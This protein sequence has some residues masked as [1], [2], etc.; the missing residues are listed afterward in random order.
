MCLIHDVGDVTF[1]VLFCLPC[2]EYPFDRVC[3]LDR[4]ICACFLGGEG[5]ISAC[6]CVVCVCV[7]VCVF[8]V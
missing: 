6:V 2:A 1:G 5:Q 4:P 3:A 7:C 8:A